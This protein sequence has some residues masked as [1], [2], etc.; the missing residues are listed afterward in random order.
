MCLFFCLSLFEFPLK[1]EEETEEREREKRAVLVAPVRSKGL[2]K[3]LEETQ[4]CLGHG[5]QKNPKRVTGKNQR[6][7]PPS[8]AR[9]LR[10]RQR[11]EREECRAIK[12]QEEPRRWSYVRCISK[13]N[14][15]E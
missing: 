13:V 12:E 5:V 6:A 8:G 7:N 14:T 9:D 4:K 11:T 15:H 3:E 1:E 2:R 10:G